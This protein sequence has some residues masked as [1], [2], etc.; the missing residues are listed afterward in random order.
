MGRPGFDLGTG[1][2]VRVYVTPSGFRA[3]T[4]FRDF[5]GKVRQVERHGK[6]RGAATAA[7]ARA[8]RD[9]HRVDAGATI[10]PETRVDALAEA[11]WSTI[12]HGS[13]SPGTLRNY[14]DRLDRQVIPSLGRLQVRELTGGTIDRHIWAV[15]D[16]HGAATAKLTRTVLSGLCAIALRH[17]ALERNPVRD[18]TPIARTIPQKAPVALTLAQAAQ[19]RALITYDDQAVGRDLPDL[20]SMMLATGL[21]IGEVCALTWD[22]INLD[23]AMV[24]T[25]GIV[26][27]VRGEGLR[28]KTDE[29]TKAKPRILRLPSWAVEMLR[30]RRD[31]G[32]KDL[33]TDATSVFPAPLGGL[34]DPS[35]TQADLRDAFAAAGFEWVTSHVL[36]KTV[37][38]AMDMAGLSARAAADQLGHSRP[39]MTTDVYMGR[40]IT[41]TGAAGVLEALA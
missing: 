41:D 13:H 31:K 15:R 35:N 10:T 7:L 37:A 21:R 18:A 6:T 24:R 20:V 14:R 30:A 36:R 12:A 2:T 27:R 4:R 40:G 8:L 3:M 23:A 16:R 33:S 25:G 39:S 9:R 26:V 1:G 34:R 29:S 17:D 11:W 22:R 32:S 28:I 38:S 5:D 19:L